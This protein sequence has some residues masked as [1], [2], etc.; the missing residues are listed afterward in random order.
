ME[1]ALYKFQITSEQPETFN[2]NRDQKYTMLWPQRPSEYNE[3]QKF[4]QF[5]EK[6]KKESIRK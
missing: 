5:S 2:N 1:K 6:H 3:R 4:E